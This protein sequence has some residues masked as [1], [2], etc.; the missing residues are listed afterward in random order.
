MKSRVHDPRRL[1]AASFAAAAGELAGSWPLA[2]F[3]RVQEAV[4]ADAPPG[5]DDLRWSAQGELRRPHAAEPQVWLHLHATARV[6]LQCQRCLQPVSVPVEVNR[7]F[8]LVAG[9]DAAARLDTEIEEDVLELTR[10]LD[11][12]ELIEDEILLALPLVPRHESCPVPLPTPAAD[13][14][15]GRQDNP[16]AELEALK[17]RLR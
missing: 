14:T 2:G 8:R 7:D 5:E 15:T 16:F 13:E 3:S 6:W 10:S 1:D 17:R 4:P 12:R 9:E 11:L